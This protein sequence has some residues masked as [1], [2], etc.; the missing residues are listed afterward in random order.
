[1][2]DI[3]LY[4]LKKYGLELSVS[5]AQDFINWY[6]KNKDKF[7]DEDSA[8]KEAA[9]YL[10]S[11]Y[12]GRPIHLYEEDLSHMKQLLSLLKKQVKKDN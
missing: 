6:E 1:M 3:R 5:E 9:K 8:D 12:K 11:E 7:V 2:K 10:Y 4:I